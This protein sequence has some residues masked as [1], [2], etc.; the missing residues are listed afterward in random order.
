[1]N[2]QREASRASDAHPYR[3]PP[4]AKARAEEDDG[5][6]EERA[7]LRGLRWVGLFLALASVARLTVA[8]VSDE[9]WTFEPTLALVMLVAPAAGAVIGPEG[10]R[11]PKAAA[12]LSRGRPPAG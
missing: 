2:E 12:R 10:P 6:A 1:M 7:S 5:D 3:A 11:A 4:P 8:V 9:E